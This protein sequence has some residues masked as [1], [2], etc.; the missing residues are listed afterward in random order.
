MYV[1]S[2]EGQDREDRLVAYDKVRLAVD[3]AY[4]DER[5]ARELSF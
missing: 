3:F 2:R 4:L 5:R 1:T